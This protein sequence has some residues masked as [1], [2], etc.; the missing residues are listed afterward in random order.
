MEDATERCYQPVL[1]VLADFPSVR[2][3]LHT[4]GPLL[5]WLIENRPETM[6]LMRQLA[7]RG[8]IEIV[9]GTHNE[10][11]AAVL[12]DRDVKGQISTMRHFCESH[13]G[14]SPRG[15]W[16]AERVWEPDLPRVLHEADVEYTLLDDVGFRFAGIDDRTVWGHFVTEKAGHP[17]TLFPIDQH[18]RYLIPFREPEE[19]L[20]HLKATAE[21]AGQPICLTYGDDGE[22]FGLWPGTYEWV[23]EQGWL[24]R[25]FQ[26]LTDAQEWLGTITL[27]EAV[28]I[29][30]TRGR[31]YLPTCSYDEMMEWAQPTDV[32]SRYHAVVDTLKKEGRFEDWRGY[33][34]GGIWQN[35]LAKYPEADRMHK[36]MIAVS[37][38]LDR[39]RQLPIQ[40]G[41]QDAEDQA[42]FQAQTALYRAQCNDAFWH[43]LFGGL[44]LTNLRM[45]TWSQLLRAESALDSLDPPDGTPEWTDID[46]DGRAECI[47]A[48]EQITTIIAPHRGGGMY[49]LSSKMHHLNVTDTLARRR[50]TYH[51]AILN[52]PSEQT[53]GAPKSIHDIHE[54]KEDGLE[55]L[56][57]YD[58]SAF[59][60]FRDR[61]LSPA[62]DGADFFERGSVSEVDIGSF[63]HADYAVGVTEAGI[64]LTHTGIIG[65]RVVRLVR[66]LT[67]EGGIVNSRVDLTVADDGGPLQVVYAPELCFNLLAPDAP[68]RYYLIDGLRPDENHMLSRGNLQGRLL[69]LIDHWTGVRISI[70]ADREVSYWR[71]P[72]QT[73]SASESGIERVYQGSL[74][75]PRF[76]L[77]LSDKQ[78]SR[79][80]IQV[81]LHDAGV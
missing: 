28:D 53:E 5:E 44:Y 22:K 10:A 24:R 70:T 39:L 15:M 64:E 69:E 8:Q 75:L 51:T 66:E 38:R 43:G 62:D 59:A 34:R 7:E 21:A 40:R 17:V 55:A 23:F 50:E 73:V 4:T 47:V 57:V 46:L 33:V 74:I 48:N 72:I 36:R 79:V 63:A 81:Q 49:E 9:G 3:S 18:L 65:D 35:F 58:P 1:E 52:G 25:F 37:N 14:Q 31:V 12:P 78:P 19:T 6:A 29:L 45:Q 67:V 80:E 77:M 30:P 42:L 13:F 76:P 41:F 20:A 61:F 56:L 71:S 27:S 11:M 16:L 54:V 60:L 26:A 2:L 68:D 32:S